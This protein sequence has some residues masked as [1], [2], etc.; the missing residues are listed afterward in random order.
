MLVKLAQ[1]WNVS[2]KLYELG[3]VDISKHQ[4]YRLFFCNKIYILPTS[5]IYEP[6]Y[7]FVRFP[8]TVSDNE[9]SVQDALAE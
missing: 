4:H 8:G 6:P 1:Q 3:I 7:N 9:Y 5:Y 2:V